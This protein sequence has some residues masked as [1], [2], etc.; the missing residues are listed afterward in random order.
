MHYLYSL[1]IHD[2]NLVFRLVQ[3]QKWVNF[4]FFF[5]CCHLCE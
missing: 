2:M 3:E 5:P 1:K 4:Y